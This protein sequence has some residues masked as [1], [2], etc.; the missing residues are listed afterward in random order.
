[1]SS[2]DTMLR[3]FGPLLCLTAL[4]SA[5]PAM[6]EPHLAV[7]KGLKCVLCHTSPSGGGMRTIY[8]NIFAQQELPANSLLKPGEVPNYWKGEINK[9]LAV[10]GDVRG[11]WTRISTPGQ[12]SLSETDL[13]EFLGYVDLR[14]IPGYLNVYVDA[15]LLPDDILVREQYVKLSTSNGRYY[16][17]GGQIFLPYGLRIQDDSAFIRQ[18]PGINYN[19]P[20]NGWEVGLEKDKWSAQFAVTRGTAGGP[21]IDSGKQ[22]SLLATYVNPGWR[23]GGSFNYNDSSA[24]KRKMQNVFGGIKT[25]RINW[26]AEIDYIVDDGTPTGRRESWMSFLEANVAVRQGHNLKLTAE[27]YDPDIDVAENQQNRYSLVWEYFPIRFVQ[28][29]V[30]FRKNNGIPQN[31]AQNQERVFAE[32]HL[33]F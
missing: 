17:R 16:I 27:F 6:A 2:A 13:E 31:P 23:V 12:A 19:T 32:L 4:L 20:D 3:R 1:M 30:G 8:G 21:E 18:V 14:L 9:Y 5:L 11:G 33:T 22:Y 15:K 10:G 7:Q 26:L 29:R 24:G 25:G 28:A